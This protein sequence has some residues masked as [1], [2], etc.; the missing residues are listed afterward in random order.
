MTRW[1]ERDDVKRGSDY[2]R[3]WKKMEA[4]G[5]SIHGEADLIG[6]F[7]P[8]AVLDAG[9]GTGRVSIEL[10]RRGIDVVGVDLDESMLAAARDKAPGIRWVRGDLIDVDIVDDDGEIRGFD[11]VALPGNV[12]IFLTPGTEGD[13][14]TNLT[15]HLAHDGCLI[16]GY[17]L[18]AGR[19]SLA[20]FDSHA[21]AAGLT[22]EHRWGTWDRE[23][24]TQGDYAVSVHR[25]EI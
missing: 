2:D 5:E 7:D 9:C 24:F 13:V 22:L 21:T 1:S 18:G 14:V 10:A 15:R 6:G 23:P 3:R 20:D 4:A 19:L 16:A 12:M 8:T 17:Q 25:R 11:V